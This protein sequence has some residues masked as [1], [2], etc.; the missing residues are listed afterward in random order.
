MELRLEHDDRVGIADRR[1]EQALRVGRRRRDRDLHAGRVHVVRLGRVVVQ[2]R[3]AH[4]A[5]VRHPDDDRE[6]HLAAGAPAVAPDVRDQLVE[7]GVART[8]RTASRTRAASRPCRARP[9][10]RGSPPPRAAC[11][12]S[13]PARSGRAALPSRGRRRR[14]GRRPRPSPARSSSRSSSTWKRVVDRLDECRAQPSEDPPQ[15]LE[16]G[17]ERRGRI[18][19][20]VLE[21]QRRVGRRLGLGRR[22]ALAHQVRR[23]ARVIASAAS[24]VRTPSRRR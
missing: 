1:R 18:D 21:E 10:C 11:R 20:R 5:A 14:R 22:D 8:R 19:E 4:A 16:V 12:R 23:L 3:R 7:A 2:L 6:L 24:S 13:G 9:R 17:A 15:L